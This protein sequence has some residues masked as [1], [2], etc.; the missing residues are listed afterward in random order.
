MKDRLGLTDEQTK[1]LGDIMAQAG[2]SRDAI[3]Q[4]YGLDDRKL[5]AMRD[6]IK[7]SRKD[8]RRQI[9]SL[10]SDEQKAQMNRIRSG[11]WV[12]KVPIAV[13]KK[14]IQAL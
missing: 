5:K 10:L 4:K 14:Y 2:Q 11:A 12:Q 3:L 7:N 6:E 13:N 8:A 1:K 9:S